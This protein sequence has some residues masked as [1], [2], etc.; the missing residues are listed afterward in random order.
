MNLIKTFGFCPIWKIPIPFTMRALIKY[1]LTP[2][3]RFFACNRI[4]EWTILFSLRNTTDVAESIQFSIATGEKKR[5]AFQLKFAPF[6]EFMLKQSYASGI[7]AGMSVLRNVIGMYCGA[8]QDHVP[9]P[10]KLSNG[11][12]MYFIKCTNPANARAYSQL[13]ESNLDNAD[14]PYDVLRALLL[15]PQLRNAHISAAGDSSNEFE[16]NLCSHAKNNNWISIVI[17][18]Q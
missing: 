14:F 11:I 9:L 16:Y 8:L 10:C 17:K 4:A 15:F 7:C 1:L 6:S 5:V 3:L 2:A 18:E 13:H 12:Y